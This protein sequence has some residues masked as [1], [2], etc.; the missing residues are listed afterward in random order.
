MSK[1]PKPVFVCQ[2]CGSQSAK[3]LGRCPDCD[4]WNSFV[5]ERAVEPA[6]GGGG[7]AAGGHRYSMPGGTGAHGQLGHGRAAEL[8][9]TPFTQPR[10][11]STSGSGGMPSDS[12]SGSRTSSGNAS[13][14]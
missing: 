8:T 9:P 2:E 7:L 4:A 1:A 14:M 13:S 12:T 6:A 3:W 10:S 5:E 11:S